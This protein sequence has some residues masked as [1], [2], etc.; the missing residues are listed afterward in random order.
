MLCRPPTLQELA[1]CNLDISPFPVIDYISNKGIPKLCSVTCT[2]EPCNCFFDTRSKMWAF[3]LPRDFALPSL[4]EFTPEA[5][6]KEDWSGIL[7]LDMTHAALQKYAHK[8]GL[9]REKGPLLVEH[10]GFELD[11]I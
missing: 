7:V 4:Q 3:P 1:L 10:F 6:I 9:E 8:R 11:T 5:K 2:F